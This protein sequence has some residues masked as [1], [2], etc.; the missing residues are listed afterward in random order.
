MPL[1]LLLLAVAVDVVVVVLVM[2]LGLLLL[3]LLLV[4]RKQEEVNEG[5][6]RRGGAVFPMTVKA[7]ARAEGQTEEFAE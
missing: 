2:R 3:L 1:L 4:K 5:L 7:M 6:R